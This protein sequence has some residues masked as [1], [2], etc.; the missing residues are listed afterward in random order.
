MKNN[1]TKCKYNNKYLKP[2]LFTDT[3]I[4]SYITTRGSK[5]TSCPQAKG[6]KKM[7]E[8][9][10]VDD[11]AIRIPKASVTAAIQLAEE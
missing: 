9:E 11:F 5:T 4:Y 3:F 8:K 7:A 1:I 2:N 10:C 6:E